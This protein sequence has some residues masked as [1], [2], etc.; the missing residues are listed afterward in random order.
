MIFRDSEFRNFLIYINKTRYGVELKHP[1]QPLLRLK[2]LCS[3]RN[4]LHNRKL[5]NL[6]N[7]LI[8]FFSYYNFV[9]H[10]HVRIAHLVYSDVYH[11]HITK[12]RTT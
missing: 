9:V 2:P 5:E 3:V 7:F 1:V 12:N 6:G 4:L 11:S 8:R 10:V